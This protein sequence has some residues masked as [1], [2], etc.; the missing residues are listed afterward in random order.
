MCYFTF[1]TYSI[2]ERIPTV[3]PILEVAVG[4]IFFANKVFV[5][6]EKR[7]G[8]FMGVIAAILSF[9]YFF[10]IELYVFTAL[11][12]GLMVLM[13]YGFLHRGSRRNKKVERFLNYT[14]TTVMAALT[15]FVFSD[16][17]TVVEFFGAIGMLSGT[18]YLTHD[19]M[20]LGWILYGSA[21]VLSAIL[22]YHVNQPFFADFQVA[23]A[24]VAAV[25]VIK[26][27]KNRL[28]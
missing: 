5:L 17:M 4:V 10:L 7:L 3:I 13:G 26:G 19:R 1:S 28:E 22:G 11:E 2:I 14:I 6:A 27:N 20:R 16:L 24:I 18:Y 9:F 25:G 12:V 23:S 8:W 15:Y 21:H